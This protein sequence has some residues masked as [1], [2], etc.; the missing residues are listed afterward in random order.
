MLRHVEV[1]LQ[2]LSQE[3]RRSLPAV[4]EAAERVLGDIR[5]ASA[6]LA[7]TGGALDVY[8]HA[9]FISQ[10]LH[11]FTL[12]CNHADASKRVLTVALAA[13]Q[14]FVTADLV[15]A[16]EY[17]NIIRVLEIQVRAA[18]SWAGGTTTQSGGANDQLRPR[19]P[20]RHARTCRRRATR[21]RCG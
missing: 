3:A 8:R 7:P 17:A 19:D 4:K 21:R 13:I 9:A 14:R 18:W 20:R 6:A 15:P 1:D 5:R 16:A 12:A 2:T 10:L 11:P